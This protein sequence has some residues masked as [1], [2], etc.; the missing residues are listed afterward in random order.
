M[1]L[2]ILPVTLC[3]TMSGILSQNLLPHHKLPIIIARLTF[4][5]L[6]ALVSILVIPNYLY[7]LFQS[8]YPVRD[9]RPS[10]FI[11]VGPPSYT[12]VGLI[13]TAEAIHAHHGYFE[14]VP[15]A[16]TTLQVISVSV[17]VYFW[18]AA[19]WFS[20]HR[21]AGVLCA[22]GPDELSPELVRFHLP[23][24]RLRHCHGGYWD[25]FGI[26]A[27]SVGIKR[28]DDQ[29]YDNVVIRNWQSLGYNLRWKELLVT[30]QARAL[31]LL[32]YDCYLLACLLF[33][34]GIGEVG[35]QVIRTER[36]CRC[37]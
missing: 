18:A 19:L 15:Q 29:H 4:Q 8:G 35:F 7:R 30:K 22:D 26:G 24:R 37:V 11:A 25:G 31:L 21:G 10:M 32:G 3:G 28:Y 9:E 12:A 34:L 6:G 13:R 5:G 17:A 16:A 36:K 2:P 14:K 33:T 20:C 1:V 23:Q 27:H